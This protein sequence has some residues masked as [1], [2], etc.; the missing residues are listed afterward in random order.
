[1]AV[2]NIQELAFT[3]CIEYLLRFSLLMTAGNFCYEGKFYATHES[4]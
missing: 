3:E 4:C 1:M 2:P